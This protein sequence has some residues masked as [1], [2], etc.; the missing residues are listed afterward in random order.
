MKILLAVT[1]LI[2]ASF[3]GETEAKWDCSQTRNSQQK[4]IKQHNTE[5][6]EPRRGKLKLLTQPTT[7]KGF[8]AYRLM[9]D[10]EFSKDLK[11]IL[12]DQSTKAKKVK[13][14]KPWLENYSEPST[15]PRLNIVLI[16]K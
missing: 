15:Q 8:Q 2:S 16:S 11:V 5:K 6:V 12:D 7:T 10:D 9:K 13:V 1:I 4:D 14:D 3:A